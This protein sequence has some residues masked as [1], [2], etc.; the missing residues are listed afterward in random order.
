MKGFKLI[1]E[2]TLKD[3]K[4]SWGVWRQ[5]KAEI[6]VSQPIP[7]YI[8]L[9]REKRKVHP[10]I[11][12]LRDAALVYIIEN[13]AGVPVYVGASL[14]DGYKTLLRHFQVWGDDSFQRKYYQPGRYRVRLVLFDGMNTQ[15]ALWAVEAMLIEAY[16][17]KNNQAGLYSPYN[18][19]SQAAGKEVAN[20]INEMVAF[21]KDSDPE[22]IETPFGDL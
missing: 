7:P 19:K 11:K 20:E 2:L 16:R 5:G 1:R 8:K 17:P 3:L 18:H 6:M 13:K 14:T 9:E 22:T 10:A 4:I 15:V 12:T 21:L